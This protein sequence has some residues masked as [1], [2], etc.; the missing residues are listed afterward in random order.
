M[1]VDVGIIEYLAIEQSSYQAIDVLIQAKSWVR[2]R[3]THDASSVYELPRTIA[4]H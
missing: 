3:A 1:R 2:P 4:Q